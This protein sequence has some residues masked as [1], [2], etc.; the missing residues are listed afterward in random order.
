MMSQR[1][2]GRAVRLETWLGLTRGHGETVSNATRVFKKKKKKEARG[3]T[4]AVYH[5]KQTQINKR[6]SPSCINENGRLDHC[7]RL[8]QHLSPALSRTA[9][10]L[11]VSTVP[12]TPLHQGALSPAHKPQRKAHTHHSRSLLYSCRQTA[13]SATPSEKASLSSSSCSGADA[14]RTSRTQRNLFTN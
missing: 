2:D 3:K 11:F 10:A 9:V 1:R 13:Q 5:H 7:H 6:T 4:L 8:H 12:A 14:L